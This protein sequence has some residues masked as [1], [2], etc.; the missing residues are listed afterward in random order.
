LPWPPAAA[1]LAGKCT[2]WYT[3]RNAR[4]TARSDGGNLMRY[5]H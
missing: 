5:A 4:L 3:A 1:R 2:N